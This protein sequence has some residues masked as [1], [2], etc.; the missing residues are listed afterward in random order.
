MKTKEGGIWFSIVGGPHDGAYFQFVPENPMSQSIL[1]AFEH[2]S[3]ATA[4][5]LDHKYRIVEFSSETMEG[6][7]MW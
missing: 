4:N 5:L 3:D 7:L 6:T 2:N 1:H